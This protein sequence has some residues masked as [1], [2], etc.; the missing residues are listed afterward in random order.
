MM[1]SPLLLFCLALITLAGAM[2]L[3]WAVSSLIFGMPAVIP[4]LVV[5]AV[6]AWLWMLPLG[7]RLGY[8]AIAGFVLDSLALPPFGTMMLLFF[9]LALAVSGLKRILASRDSRAA[10]IAGMMLFYGCMMLGT[11]VL[12]GAAGFL[13]TAGL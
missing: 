13:Y 12:R 3:Q 1:R 10:Q 2:L 7:W 6:A 9:I 11:F 5:L 8:A 4:S